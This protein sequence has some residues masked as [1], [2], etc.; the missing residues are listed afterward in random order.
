MCKIYVISDME[1]SLWVTRPKQIMLDN[2]LY[3]DS[4]KILIK[5]INAV[6]KGLFNGNANEIYFHYYHG[7]GSNW[8]IDFSEIDKRV[9]IVKGLGFPYY[10]IPGYE[11]GFDATV[12]TGMHGC[13]G[14]DNNLLGHTLSGADIEAVYVNGKLIGEPTILSW[15][16][17]YLKMPVI[18]LSGNSSACEEIKESNPKIVTV[19]NK[20][21]LSPKTALS[22]PVD[23]LLLELEEKAKEAI[24]SM[25][26]IGY[27]KI[28]DKMEVEVELKNVFTAKIVESS[29]FEIFKR[30]GKKI[31]FYA[32]NPVILFKMLYVLIA[33][34]K[35]A[36][37][38]SE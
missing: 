11:I 20:I 24:L 8:E 13:G 4:T 23:R 1:G 29:P 16:L 5:E 15:L 21:D 38:F 7:I 26:E 30:S 32:D 27:A 25:K 9:Y 2:P 31:T 10:H 33:F 35:L 37:A 17:S 36:I 14:E 22:K 6:I 28:P 19:S 12:L 3:K 34:S 18:F